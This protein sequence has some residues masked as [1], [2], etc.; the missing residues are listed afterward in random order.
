MRIFY[1]LTVLIMTT[2]DVDVNYSVIKFWFDGLYISRYNNF[3]QHHFNS[4][5]H[6]CFTHVGNI[7][8]SI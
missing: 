8:T 4:A 1:Y 7:V 3:F 5:H 2:V 6:I